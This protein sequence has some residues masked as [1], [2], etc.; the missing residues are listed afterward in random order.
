MSLPD[1]NDEAK[2][3]LRA[4]A[5]PVRDFANPNIVVV[6]LDEALAI[7]NSLA[8]SSARNTII[9]ECAKAIEDAVCLPTCDSVAHDEKCPYVYPE[10]AIRALSDGSGA[11]HIPPAPL[12]ICP[13]CGVN[14]YLENCPEPV[15]AN[16]PMVGDTSGPK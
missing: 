1:K 10:A 3:Y 14:R 13:R 4:A 6:R 2:G 16:C 15:G 9:E 11:T 7:L 12:G 5:M 8:P